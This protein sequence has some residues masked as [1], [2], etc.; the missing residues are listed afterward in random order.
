MAVVVKMSETCQWPCLF[1]G[2]CTIELLLLYEEPLGVGFL[3]ALREIAW[4]RPN[5]EPEN[6]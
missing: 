4:S 5:R 3:P 2:L 6:H 1:S